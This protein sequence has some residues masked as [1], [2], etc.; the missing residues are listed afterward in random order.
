MKLCLVFMFALGLAACTE[1][2]RQR[3]AQRDA[4]GAPL[5]ILVDRETG[6]QYLTAWQKGIT[7]RLSRRG[8]HICSLTEPGPNG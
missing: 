2:D 4:A 3:Q 5:E 6:C 1:A 8:Q 7:P